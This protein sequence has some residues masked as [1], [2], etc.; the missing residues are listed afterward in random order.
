MV[1]FFLFLQLDFFPFFVHLKC[2]VYVYFFHLFQFYVDDSHKP[3]NIHFQ[4]PS[5]DGKEE[6]FN[7]SV[8]M[9]LALA[10]RMECTLKTKHRRNIWTRNHFLK[11]IADSV[12]F[13]TFYG[14]RCW[15][16]V[17]ILATATTT[18]ITTKNSQNIFM[19]LDFCHVSFKFRSIAN[20]AETIVVAWNS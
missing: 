20:V 19:L 5:Q 10:I 6:K 17:D 3:T 18:T 1:S 7:Q 2:V 14:I 11:R 16:I 13:R 12:H 4:R 15:I 9:Y 8:C